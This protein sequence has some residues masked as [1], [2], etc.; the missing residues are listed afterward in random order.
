M[1]DAPGKQLR[2]EVAYALPGEQ[3][4]LHLEVEEGTTV[5]GT[6]ERS[7]ILQ[8]FPGLLARH[9]NVGVFGRVV[10]LD[11]FVRDGASEST[12]RTASSA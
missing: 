1:R 11:A 5:G 4:L 6:I 9:G 10:E 2:V 7:G 3:V 8:R 12:S